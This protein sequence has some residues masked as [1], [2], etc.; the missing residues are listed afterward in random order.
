M[1]VTMAD[2]TVPPEVVEMA[3]QSI[4]RFFEPI[5]KVDP[6]SNAVD[7]LELSKSFKRAALLERYESLAGKKVLEVGSGFGTNLAVW[8]RHFEADAYGVEPGG[9]GF[10]QGYIASRRLLASNGIE[11]DRV[12]DSAGESLPFPDES[13][14]IVYSANVLEHTENPGRVLMEA[15]R[16][17]RPG[18]LLHMEMP[19]FLSYF[20]GHYMVVMPPIVWKPI[21]GWWMKLVFR[22][23]PAFARTLRTEINPFWCRRQMKRA[24]Q[25]YPLKTISLGEDVFLERLTNS[26]R[27][28][29][30]AV[31]NSAGG[32][33]AALQR[34]NRRNWIGRLIVALQGHYPIYLSARKGNR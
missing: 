32:L 13:F 6:R 5:C 8:I 15:L 12:I 4:G 2:I 1:P 3:A 23:D 31:A 19:N 10:N 34:I 20:E 21:L 11:P 17:L 7:F 30:Q 18:G 14:D 28:E 16:V 22:R 29:T 27:F 33:I 9:V 26:F 25:I 24:A